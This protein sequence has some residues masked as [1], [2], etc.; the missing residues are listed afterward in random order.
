MANKR[1]GSDVNPVHEFSKKVHEKICLALSFARTSMLQTSSQRRV[2]SA[3]TVQNRIVWYSPEWTVPT[4]NENWKLMNWDG[5]VDVWKR[6]LVHISGAF[7]LICFLKW[8]KFNL[9]R[10]FCR[11]FSPHISF[12]RVCYSTHTPFTFFFCIILCRY[13]YIQ[14]NS[15][16]S[17]YM[18]YSL[19]RG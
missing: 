12:S 13:N 1:L 10:F 8:A 16:T 3:D 19:F 7:D 4:V 5:G 18:P 11:A 14:L 6:W 15:F 17:E 2:N 9:N